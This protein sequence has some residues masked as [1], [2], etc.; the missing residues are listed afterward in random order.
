MPS[1][2]DSSPSAGLIHE[3]TGGAGP[4]A[5]FV[6]G[7]ALLA[8][9]MGTVLLVLATAFPTGTNAEGAYAR[10]DSMLS[11]AFDSVGLVAARNLVAAAGALAIVGTGILARRI[12]HH[13]GVGL[14]AATFVALDP[15]FLAAGHL[16]LPTVPLLGFSLMGA[17]LLSTSKDGLRWLGSLSLGA[18]AFL[19]PVL[20][21]WV[22]PL[23]LLV[24]LR[25]NIYAAP[26]HL[27]SAAARVAALPFVGAVGGAVL[28][29]GGSLACLQGSAVDQFLLAR[30]AD[31]GPVVIVHNPALWFG[32]L[33]ALA[34]LGGGATFHVLGNFRLARLPGRVQV[35]LPEP[36]PDYHARALWLLLLAVAAPSPILWMPVLA[37]ALAAGM[38]HL[39]R[40][41]P[42]F[43][44]VVALASVAFGVLYLIRL[45]PLVTGSATAADLADLLP[46]VPWAT[47]NFCAG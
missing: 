28:G 19:E 36:L 34:I 18:A 41:A 21:L 4:G 14:L 6:A 38:R 17:A 3:R 7:L 43:G 47:A 27:V 35:R 46:V 31:A 24:L 22:V 9:V 42:G 20:A 44:L 13:D 5:A 37:I 45:W 2:P 40:D 23:F 10:E 16:A 15:A 26:K 1:A 32:G 33:A 11:R 8:L 25:G 29:S 30:A 39:A 12:F